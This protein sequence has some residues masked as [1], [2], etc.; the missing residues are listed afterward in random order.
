MGGPGTPA[1]APGPRID[2]S[3]WSRDARRRGAAHASAFLGA[4]DI[5]I[6]FLQYV[7]CIIGDRNAF[8]DPPLFIRTDAS[9]SDDSL[10]RHRN[11]AVGN[12][13]PFILRCSKLKETIFL[14]ELIGS[15]NLK[16]FG[17]YL[18]IS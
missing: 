17:K 14:E 9:F 15:D 11:G 12:T 13:T 2:R 8:S 16:V 10:R 3:H 4:F 1:S 6:L 5:E 18:S 7:S